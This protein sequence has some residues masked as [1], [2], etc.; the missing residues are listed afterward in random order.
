MKSIELT[1]GFCTLVDDEDFEWLNQFTWCVSDSG[2]ENIY[3]YRKNGNKTEYLHRLIGAKLG[4]S[5]VDHIDRNTLNNQKTNLR[6][7]SKSLNALNV[8]HKGY[9]ITPAGNFRAQL[10]VNGVQVLNKVYKTQAEAQS[11]YEQMKQSYL[12]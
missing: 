2:N 4:F 8:K 1:R 12:V 5:M 7:T 6:Q 11:A 10:K 9:T 3:A